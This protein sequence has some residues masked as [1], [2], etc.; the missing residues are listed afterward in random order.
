MLQWKIQGGKV[1]YSN[2]QEVK[3][4]SPWI[5]NS[6]KSCYPHFGLGK[7]DQKFIINFSAIDVIGYF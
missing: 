2:I 1:N 3:C 4:I 5:Y 6:V 7:L